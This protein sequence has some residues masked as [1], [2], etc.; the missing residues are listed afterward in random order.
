MSLPILSS[1]IHKFNPEY[2]REISSNLELYKHPDISKTLQQI[3][4]IAEG[5]KRVRPYLTFLMDS[6][7]NE[8]NHQPFYQAI[9]LIH[10]F[11][12]IHDDIMDECD[13]RR[14]EPTIHCHS[15][16]FYPNL[17][18]AKNSRITESIAI[19]AGDLVFSLAEKSFVNGIKKSTQKENALK[20]YEYFCMLKEEVI[21]GQLLDLHLSAQK[22]ASHQEVYDKTFYKTASYTVIKPLQ[23]GCILA[24]RD[25]L[26]DF[27]HEFGESLGVA[28]QIQDDYIN[29]TVPEEITGK[30]QYSDVLEGQKTFFTVYLQGHEE[31]SHWEYYQS[32]LSNKELNKDQS[33]NL[34]SI[35]TSSNALQAGLEEF[36][37]LYSKAEDILESNKSN[38]SQDSYQGLKELV[39]Y[40]KTRRK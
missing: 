35:L 3:V 36:T 5:G 18:T 23:I 39:E 15:R 8:S 6:S 16:Q 1:F 21:Y 27:C 32:L 11:A 4:P 34:K 31:K 25:D 20:A 13:N 10:L 38:L 9:E 30:P 26:L 17:P 22:E 14:G 24:G 12:L 7:E 37:K 29:L 28:F 19:L 40:L 2:L 33:T